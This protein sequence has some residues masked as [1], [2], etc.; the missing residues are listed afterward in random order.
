MLGILDTNAGNRD[1]SEK[2]SKRIYKTVLRQFK[3]LFFFSKL[4]LTHPKRTAAYQFD[5]LNERFHKLFSRKYTVDKE[6]FTYEQELNR[7]YNIAYDSYFMKPINLT[8]DLFKVQKRIY[9]VD[10]PLYME[11]KRYTTKDVGIQV[12]PGDHKTFL[13]PPNDKEFA[14]LLQA[15]LDQRTRG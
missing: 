5:I 8:I 13:L 9:Y 2:K 4:F 6:F 11:W 15:R 3:K 7:S 10:D 14:R 1:P 12:V